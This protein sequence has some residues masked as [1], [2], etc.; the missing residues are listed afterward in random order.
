MKLKL[1]LLSVL[2]VLLTSCGD[3]YSLGFSHTI[4]DEVRAYSHFLTANVST[5]SKWTA[6]VDNSA[7][8]WCRLIYDEEGIGDILVIEVDEN[9]TGKKRTATITVKIGK[10]VVQEVTFT[11]RFFSTI[12]FEMKAYPVGDYNEVYFS[13]HNCIATVDW[14]D[15]KITEQ[16]LY[17][18]EVNPDPDYYLWH[19]YN[20]KDLQTIKVSAKSDANPDWDAFP[21]E[22]IYLTIDDSSYPECLGIYKEIR[23]EESNDPIYLSLGGAGFETVDVQLLQS[24][25]SLSVGGNKLTE[26]TVNNENSL[27]HYVNCR[28]NL[29]SASALDALFTSLPMVGD[30]DMSNEILIGN[31]PGTSEC[32]RSIAE[33]KGW[34]IIDEW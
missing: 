32:N 30:I 5:D 4:G 9:D 17:R 27:L 10:T 11:Q 25:I 3:D 15:G 18:T 31:N 24:L 28:G 6:A 8:D 29:L 1:L 33:A 22:R 23:F 2:S 7:K 34:N 12:K 20:N 19:M 13:M 26:L 21:Y 16:N 14:G